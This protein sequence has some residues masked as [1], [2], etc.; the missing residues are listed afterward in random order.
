M[1]IN[2]EII[3]NWL[4]DQNINMHICMTQ[5]QFSQWTE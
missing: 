2:L 4:K 5:G 1:K 3:K